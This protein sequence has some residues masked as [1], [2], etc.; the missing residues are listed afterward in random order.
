MIGHTIEDRL[1]RL[2]RV[3]IEAR[4]VRLER[5]MEL[6]LRAFAP[7]RESIYQELKQLRRDMECEPLFTAQKQKAGPKQTA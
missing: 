1:A 5:A 6:A 4:L 7:D 3:E 2:E